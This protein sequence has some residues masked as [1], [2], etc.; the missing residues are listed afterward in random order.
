MLVIR[1][2]FLIYPIGVVRLDSLSQVTQSKKYAEGSGV[3]MCGGWE[4]LKCICNNLE[5]NFIR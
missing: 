5:E 3:A 2:R 4:D 1:P